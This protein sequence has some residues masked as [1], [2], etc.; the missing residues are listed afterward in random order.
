MVFCVEGFPDGIGRFSNSV[1]FDEF[2]CH[3]ARGQ[4]TVKCDNYFVVQLLGSRAELDIGLRRFATFRELRWELPC[5]QSPA[6]RSWALQIQ[7]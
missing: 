6:L 1:S 2:P 3:H 7:N 5:S 4:L